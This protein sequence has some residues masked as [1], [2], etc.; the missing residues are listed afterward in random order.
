MGEIK[1]EP[2]FLALSPHAH[3]KQY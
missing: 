2:F 3:E 1:I